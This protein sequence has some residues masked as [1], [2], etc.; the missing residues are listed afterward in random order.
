MKNIVYYSVD[1]KKETPIYVT[2]ETMKATSVFKTPTPNRGMW[3][4]RAIAEFYAC[5]PKD[6]VMTIID[7]GAHAGL[8]TMYAKLLPN[9]NFHAFEPCNITY[10]LLSGNVKLNGLKNVHCYNMGISST[11]GKSI[12]NTS[13]SSLGLHTMGSNPLRFK[14]IKP[15][16][17]ITETLDNLFYDK[18]IP[19]VKAIKID[20]EGW[21]YHILK[22]AEKL[23]KK[24]KPIIQIEWVP[25]NMQQCGISVKQMTDLLSSIGYYKYKDNGSEVIIKAK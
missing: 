8:Y 18:D 9:A 2:D 24:Y 16:E 15:V 5:I 7:V 23:I 4:E 6:E 20:T 10:D 1:K 17:I 25:I 13:I 3:E 12:L 11:S 22:G 21:E 19:P 14:D